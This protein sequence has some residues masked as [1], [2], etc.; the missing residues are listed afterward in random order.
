KRP[1]GFGFVEFDDPRDADEARDSMDGQRL[2]SNYV[3]VEVAKQRRKSPKTMRR[4]DD[5][6]RG[7][8]LSWRKALSRRIWWRLHLK[9]PNEKLEGWENNMIDPSKLEFRLGPVSER[10]SGSEEYLVVDPRGQDI[11][12]GVEFEEA[13]HI[14]SISMRE[15][16]EGRGTEAEALKHLLKYIVRTRPYVRRVT[17][18]PGWN[19]R[20]TSFYKKAGFDCQGS[21][22]KEPRSRMSLPFRQGTSVLL[23]DIRDEQREILIQYQDTSQEFVAVDTTGAQ[24]VTGRIWFKEAVYIEG[25][26]LEAVDEIDDEA[27]DKENYGHNANAE[28]H[29]V[30]DTKVKN[31]NSDSTGSTEDTTPDEAE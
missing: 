9:D 31:N 5:E 10:R 2:G 18:N 16:W 8:R 15:D 4:L 23:G 27:E 14:H 29:D 30:Q 24:E 20:R 1:R 19:E 7:D 3:E 26:E 13:V 28:M 6:Y 25:I 12:G 21:S 17:A 11:L 22:S